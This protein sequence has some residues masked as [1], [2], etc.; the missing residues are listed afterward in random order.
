MADDGKGDNPKLKHTIKSAIKVRAKGYL[1]PKVEG[2]KPS[3]LGGVAT[4]SV[5]RLYPASAV[6][7]AWSD[8]FPSEH[9]NVHA[10]HV[11][12]RWTTPQNAKPPRPKP[13]MG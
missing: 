13:T 12:H 5:S 11:L 4:Y 10:M 6:P 1:N 8:G 3:K 2:G 9:V 7:P